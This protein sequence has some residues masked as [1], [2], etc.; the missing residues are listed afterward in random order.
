M[1][2]PDI[3]RKLNLII[4]KRK[5]ENGEE[6]NFIKSP[7]FKERSSI[8]SGTNSYELFLYSGILWGQGF[9]GQ[10]W[11]ADKIW[12][13]DY[14][15]NKMCYV[16]EDTHYNTEGYKSVPIGF[17]E[18]ASGKRQVSFSRIQ[19]RIDGELFDFLFDTG[20]TVNLSNEAIRVLGNGN[21]AIRGISFITH[22]IFNK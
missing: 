15:R 13:L 2:E 21:E 11:F 14:Q 19:A 12:S 16:V 20:A 9:L 6:V 18:D 3:V 10:S 1:I 4:F 17:K 5:M 22:S 7:Q 8:P